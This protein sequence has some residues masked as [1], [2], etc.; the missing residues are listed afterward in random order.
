MNWV[1]LVIIITFLGYTILGIYQGFIKSFFELVG[2]VLSFILAILL[3]SWAGK[4]FIDYFS[5]PRSFSNALGFLVVW[6]VFECLYF[7]ILNFLYRKIPK[8]IKKSIWNK[9]TGFAP[10]LL[11]AFVI[12]ALVLTTI[13]SFPIPERIKSDIL[14]SRLGKPFVSKSAWLERTIDKVFGGAVNDTITFL[15]VKPESEEKVDLNFQTSNI[16]IDERSE[17]KML[18]L[19]NK[20]R[21][22]RG[23]KILIVDPVIREV[24]RAHSKDMFIRGYFSHEN[25][26]GKSP[27][28]RMREG[29]VVFRAA[30]ENLAL[31]PDVYLA[32][33]GLMDSPGHRANI[34]EPEFGRVG[35]GCYDGGQYGKMFTQNFAN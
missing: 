26:D 5:I 6:V 18:D 2:F 20:E 13:V 17:I 22:K 32:H 7:A 31:A 25:P 15:T 27:F 12:L 21:Q 24:A 29:G 33:Q 35:I 30:G 3:Y 11:K 4:I 34:L 16:T 23:L 10:S 28:D 8:E 1:D 9:A 19:V 14:N